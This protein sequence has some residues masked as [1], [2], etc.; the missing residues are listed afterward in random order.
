MKSYPAYPVYAVQYWYG[1][2][3]I[4]NFSSFEE[5]TAFYEGAVQSF[6]NTRYFHGWEK[7]QFNR[8]RK[9]VEGNRTYQR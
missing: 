6:A 9:E 8:L 4:L 7:R 1:G 2:H 3:A 5:F